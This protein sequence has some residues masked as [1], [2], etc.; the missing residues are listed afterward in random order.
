MPSRPHAPFLLGS[1]S[2]LAPLS[3]AAPQVILP[4]SQVDNVVHLPPAATA[5]QRTCTGDVDGDAA[6]DVAVL[7]SSQ[8]FVSFSTSAHANVLSVL[9][10]T[11]V[12]DMAL[13]P[14]L[15]PASR[16]QVAFTRPFRRRPPARS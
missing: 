4:Y 14:R 10:S 12:I 11:S 1:L 9:P 3:A 16:S 15:G 7:A 5:V 2:L 13:T 6:P 8:M